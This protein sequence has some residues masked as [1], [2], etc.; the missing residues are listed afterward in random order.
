MNLLPYSAS[1]LKD[2]LETLF[3]DGMT[4]SRLMQGEIEIDHVI[5]VSF[6]RPASHDSLEFK[7]CWSLR[8]LQPLWREDNRAKKD[9]LPDNFTELWNALYEEA[10]RL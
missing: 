9:F 5:P 3:T 4:W 6:F 8:N 7:M 10:I 1:D 2:H